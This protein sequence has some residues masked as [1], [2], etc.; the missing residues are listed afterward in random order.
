VDAD[1]ALVM[2]QLDLA[3]QLDVKLSSTTGGRTR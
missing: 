2:E 3:V 1:G